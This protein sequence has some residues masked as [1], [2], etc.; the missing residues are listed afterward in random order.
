MAAEMD[1]RIRAETAEKKSLRDALQALLAW[2]EKNHR[3]FQT[4]EMTEIFS[5]QRVWTY[6]TS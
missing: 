2:S 5:R 3:A 4:E 1:E 6:R